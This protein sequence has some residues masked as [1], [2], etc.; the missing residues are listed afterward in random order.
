MKFFLF[1]IIF[2]ALILIVIFASDIALKAKKFDIRNGDMDSLS[3]D[4]EQSKTGIEENIIESPHI[5]IPLGSPPPQILNNQENPEVNEAVGE[6]NFTM[7]INGE[8]V[9][10]HFGE[11][12]GLDKPL[13]LEDSGWLMLALIVG[14]II[15]TILLGRFLYSESPLFNQ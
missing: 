3:S 15:S 10:N 14:S 8:C 5:S 7:V 11:A 6:D 12:F 2:Y 9:S 13:S 4:N 1:R